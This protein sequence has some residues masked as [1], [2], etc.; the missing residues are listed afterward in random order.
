MD[1]A[2][3]RQ[4][5]AGTCGG[6]VCLQAAA[7][8]RPDGPVSRTQQSGEA[9][10]RCRLRRL[11]APRRASP[12]SLH[13]ISC[14]RPSALCMAPR[15]GN[16]TGHRAQSFQAKEVDLWL[17]VQKNRTPDEQVDLEVEVA[18]LH[19]RL[20]S[21]PVRCREHCALGATCCRQGQCVAGNIVLLGRTRLPG[22]SAPW[23]VKLPGG[24]GARLPGSPDKRL[25][26]PWPAALLA[27]G[28]VGA[29]GAAGAAYS[30]R[31]GTAC[32]QEHVPACLTTSAPRWNTMMRSAVS[33]GAA[34]RPSGYAAQ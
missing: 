22:A 10:L 23:H 8:A 2:V 17:R 34:S 27:R 6:A 16:V 9:G 11:P 33:A 15:L 25:P 30:P 28:A 7:P 14:V 1:T 29:A 18:A 19:Q 31:M 21:G 20:Q 5:W 24:V 4:R 13:S 26:T 32:Y 3:S 12:C